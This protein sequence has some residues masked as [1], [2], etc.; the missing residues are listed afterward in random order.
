MGQVNSCWTGKVRTSKVRKG[1]VR[2]GQERTGQI[3]IG[4]FNRS[5]QDGQ[6]RTGQV[7][8]GLICLPKCTWDWSLTLALAQLVFYIIKTLEW[9]TA[10]NLVR[11]QTDILQQY[12]L[13]LIS[14]LF[15]LFF[16][17]SDILVSH[18]MASGIKLTTASRNELF[19]YL[20]FYQLYLKL[21]PFGCSLPFSVS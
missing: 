14:S 2:V 3:S 16:L 6:F 21:G 13:T 7:R 11:C 5:S 15:Y 17:V 12:H 19:L 10:L 20:Q 9:T 8:T 18:M 4:Q 1:Q